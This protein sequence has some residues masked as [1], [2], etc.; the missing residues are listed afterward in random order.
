VDLY[1]SFVRISYAGRMLLDYG[2]PLWGPVTIDGQQIVET[3]NF[4]ASPTARNFARG[5]ETHVIRF[6]LCRIFQSMEDAFAARL[7]AMASLPRAESGLLIE[8]RD[9]RKWAMTSATA[10][11][12]SGLQEERMT[13]EVVEIIGGGLAPFTGS[14]T[15]SPR[16]GANSEDYP[17]GMPTAPWDTEKDWDGIANWEQLK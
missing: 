11:S 7:S 10:R 16:W 3:V 8:L 5:N 9:G 12:W 17:D 6:E 14:V 15:A 13:R 1:D 4:V 2:D